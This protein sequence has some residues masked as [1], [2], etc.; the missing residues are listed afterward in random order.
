MI[1]TSNLHYFL[2]EHIYFSDLVIGAELPE[3]FGNEKIQTNQDWFREYCDTD[4]D[5]R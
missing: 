1:I 4:K 3:M 5:K 2:E